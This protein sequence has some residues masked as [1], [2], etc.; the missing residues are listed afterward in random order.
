MTPTL[1]RKKQQTQNNPIC[2][3]CSSQLQED[4]KH[5]FLN[6]P[7]VLS[8]KQTLK[9]IIDATTQT[10]TDIDSAI[11]LFKIPRNKNK[12]KHTLNILTLAEYKQHIWTIY[13]KTRYEHKHFPPDIIQDIFRYKLEVLLNKHQPPI[14]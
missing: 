14:Q 11:T 13:L 10:D 5:I 4:E 7:A 3:L 12:L 8:T 9:L 1:D 6:C 2:K